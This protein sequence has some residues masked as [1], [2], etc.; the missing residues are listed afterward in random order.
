MQLISSLNARWEEPWGRSR[1]SWSSST[2]AGVWCNASGEIHYLVLFHPITVCK[3]YKKN[4]FAI[5][6]I[7]TKLIWKEK[8]HSFHKNCKE[9]E[10]ELLSIN[11]GENSKK[12]LRIVMMTV[13]SLHGFLKN[14]FV[15]VFFSLERRRKKMWCWWTR[16]VLFFFWSL[17]GPQSSLP[18]S[19]RAWKS[20]RRAAHVASL[21]SLPSYCP[22]R[23]SQRRSRGFLYHQRKENAWNF[24]HVLRI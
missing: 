22:L 16:I 3:K 19:T 24:I 13:H 1:S 14:Y 4:K 15:F 20:I 6:A 7:K 5:L 21:G 10:E 12:I 2:C 8:G 9:K 23:R 18:S 11:E 17:I